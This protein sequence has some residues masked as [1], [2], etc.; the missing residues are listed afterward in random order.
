MSNLTAYDVGGTDDY[1]KITYAYTIPSDNSRFVRWSFVYDFGLDTNASGFSSMKVSAYISIAFGVLVILQSFMMNKRRTNFVRFASDMSAACSIIFAVIYLI[2]SYQLNRTKTAL[3]WDF[4]ASGICSLGIQL[5]DAYTFLSRCKAVT[6]FPKWKL[7][8]THIYIVLVIVLPNYSTLFF[9]PLFL[10]MN[11]TIGAYFG[12]YA[13]MIVL[14]GTIGYNLYFTA[15]FLYLAH[16]LN[17]KQ[18]PFTENQNGLKCIIYKNL[19]HCA[20]SSIANIILYYYSPFNVI[21]FNMVIVFGIH[22]LF[23]Y[24]IENSCVV[25]RVLDSKMLQT[26]KSSGNSPLVQ[27]SKLSGKSSIAS[28]LRGAFSI[29]RRGAFSYSR[30]GAFSI[31]RRDAFSFSR[32]GAFSI[33]RKRAFSISSMNSVHPHSIRRV[34]IV[35]SKILQTSKSSGNSSRIK[36]T[37]ASTIRNAFSIS[38]MNSVRPL[39][40]RGTQVMPAFEE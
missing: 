26:S 34:Q 4:C 1:F 16:D 17:K 13:F 7:Y 35:D 33:P 11:S 31:S 10:D 36:S 15:E 27:T 14:W 20:T 9:L 38:S 40:I 5:T 2:S 21:M 6:K 25:T 28:T 18:T 29:S 3:A 32:R 19:V 24:K 8:F 12:Q 37:L 30:R 23:N 22:F 39:A